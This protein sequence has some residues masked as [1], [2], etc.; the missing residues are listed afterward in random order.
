M[1]K[2]CESKPVYE[3]TNKRKVCKQ[4]FIRWFEKKFLYTI[5]KFNMVRNEDVIFHQDGKGFRAVV[6]S[7]LLDLFQTKAQVKIVHKSV[8]NAKIAHSTTLDLSAEFIIT[9]LIKGKLGREADPVIAN[10]IKPLYLFLDKEVLL[11]AKLKKLK[12]SFWMPKRTFLD[13]LEC[14]HPELKWAIVNGYLGLNID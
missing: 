9:I 4:C 7:H 12:H 1:C 13:E 10:V 14:K 2:N 8:R 3:F 6:L 5:R 11:Y